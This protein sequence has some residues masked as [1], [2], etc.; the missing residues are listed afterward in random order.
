MRSL[1]CKAFAD[2]FGN[3][4]DKLLNFHVL[5][6]WSSG[7]LTPNI[8]SVGGHVRNFDHTGPIDRF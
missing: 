4:E 5:P 2:G 7:T 3:P 6:L 8:E 1:G